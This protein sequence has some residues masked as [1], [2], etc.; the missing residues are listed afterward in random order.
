MAA[1]NAAANAL[2]KQLAKERKKELAAQR[3]KGSTN[4][5]KTE[6]LDRNKQRFELT[7]A[8]MINDGDFEEEGDAVDDNPCF[9]KALEQ[10]QGKGCFFLTQ[11][12]K[13]IK[14]NDESGSEDEAA[15][16]KELIKIA[17]TQTGTLFVGATNL[18]QQDSSMS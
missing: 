3:T 14:D 4:Y 6:F 5:N 2:K 10:L 13:L 8:S 1:R 16:F 12:D 11:N 18:S 17:N 15:K 7:Q 9:T